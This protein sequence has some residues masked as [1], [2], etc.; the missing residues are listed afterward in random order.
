MND[1][2][3]TPRSATHAVVKND[4][5]LLALQIDHQLKNMSVPQSMQSIKEDS[6]LHSM[7]SFHAP[8]VEVVIE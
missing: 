1:D 3:L 6:H 8:P 4:T 5:S 7:G 2:S